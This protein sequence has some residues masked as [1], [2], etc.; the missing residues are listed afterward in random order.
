MVLL[1][2]L[3]PPDRGD[4]RGVG[5]LKIGGSAKQSLDLGII[6]LRPTLWKDLTALYKSTAGESIRQTLRKR[7]TGYTKELSSP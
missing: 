6:I 2:P 5:Q 1:P 3:F 4:T 7:L